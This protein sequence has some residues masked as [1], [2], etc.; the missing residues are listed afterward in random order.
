MEIF[1]QELDLF[2]RPKVQNEIT[3]TFDRE[4]SPISS[5]QHGSPIE[6][7]IPGSQNLYLDLAKSYL[8]IRCKITTP[9]NDNPA[10]DIQ[11]GIINLPLHSLFSKVDI[12]LGGKLISDSNGLYCYRAYIETLLNSGMDS[13]LSQ[14]QSELFEKDTANHF[15]DFAIGDDVPNKGLHKRAGHFRGGADVELMGRIHGDIFNQQHAILSNVNLKIKLYPCA[16]NFILTTP[17]PQNNA[18]QINYKIHILDARMLIHTIHASEYV[19]REHEKLLQNH[20]AY[21]PLL[22]VTMKIISVPRGQTSTMHDN[23]YLGQLPSKIALAMVTDESMAGGYQQNPFNFEHF[24]LNYLALYAN[25]ELIPNRPYQPNF[26]H[27]F[28]IKDYQSLFEGKWGSSSIINRYDYAHGYTIWLF[29]LAPALGSESKPGSV[30]LELK[31]AQALGHTI[32]IILYAEF[33]SHL[34]IDKYRNVSLING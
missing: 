33:D 15:H 23:I 17:P 3:K 22:N 1:N 8:Y 30:R 12:E 20:F 16:N 11:V 25:G 19:I 5:I 13:A 26:E 7:I 9:T 10:N 32:N 2:L 28:Y 31:F 6:F 4:F 21:Y 18:A 27:N 24:N 14:L 34:Q 29:N